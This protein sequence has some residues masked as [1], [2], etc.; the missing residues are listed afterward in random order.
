MNRVSKRPK[1]KIT[2]EERNRWMAMG[3]EIGEAF[4]IRQQK[5]EQR[6][7][8]QSSPTANKPAQR[9]VVPP[10]IAALRER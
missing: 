10:D 8:R 3:Q 2:T 7:S 6:E 9:H 1:I 5:K 4:R